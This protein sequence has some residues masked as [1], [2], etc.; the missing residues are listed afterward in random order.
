MV[1]RGPA[2]VQAE[3]WVCCRLRREACGVRRG[4]KEAQ[5]PPSAHTQLRRHTTWSVPTLLAAMA[6][7]PRG[8]W[9][10]GAG[11][12]PELTPTLPLFC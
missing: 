1:L 3:S 12:Q 4:C 11:A 5:G 8:V 2:T 6:R 10:S 7:S 9:V